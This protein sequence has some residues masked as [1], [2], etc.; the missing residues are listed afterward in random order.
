MIDL[1][2]PQI[3]SSLKS[4][5][6]TAILTNAFMTVLAA[7][8]CG[9]AV[10]V[11][12][13]KTKFK[14]TDWAVGVFIALLVLIVL[15]CA[16]IVVWEVFLKRPYRRIAH[17]YVA[18]RLTSCPSLFEGGGVAEFELCIA[19]DKLALLRLGCEQYAVC[20]LSPIRRYPAMCNYTLGLIKKYLTD[21][22]SLNGSALGIEKVYLC[23]CAR[24]GA[25]AKKVQLKVKDDKQFSKSFFIASQ[26]ITKI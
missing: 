3:Q 18:E 16:F 6:I 9:L 5:R 17:R 19:G 22:Y 21:Y 10:W 24:G 2:S 8:A 1:S 15:L 11:V 26:I 20:D 12:V 4:N 23:D 14:L 13:E 7:I 25:K